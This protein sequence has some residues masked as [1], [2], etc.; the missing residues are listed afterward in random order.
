M[1]SRHLVVRGS[2]TG[3]M[4]KQGGVQAPAVK[5]KRTRKTTMNTTVKKTMKKTRKKIT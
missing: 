4:V 1:N 3:S 2:R 5:E